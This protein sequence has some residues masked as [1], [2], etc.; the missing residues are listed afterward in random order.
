MLIGKVKE[1]RSLK[2][3]I[4][5]LLLDYRHSTR[6]W[7]TT[8]LFK[9][10]LKDFNKEMRERKEL[11]F[12]FSTTHQSM[13]RLWKRWRACWISRSNGCPLIAR[14]ISN[15]QMQDRY[16]KWPNQALFRLWS[17]VFAGHQAGLT[18]PA[19]KPYHQRDYP[20]SEWRWP[21]GHKDIVTVLLCCSS[22]GV[23]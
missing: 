4:D 20:H 11:L 7:M 8:N 22:I 6:A 13:L 9:D 5:K 12:S 1:P 16:I 23:K 14:E 3:K 21:S 10:W 19:A 18:L 2:V 17:V 15:R